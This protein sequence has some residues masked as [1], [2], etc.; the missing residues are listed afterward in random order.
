MRRLSF[1]FVLL[2]PGCAFFDAFAKGLSGGETGASGAIAG[3][4]AGVAEVIRSVPTIVDS[5]AG[6]GLVAG[7]IVAALTIWKAVRKGLAV[8]KEKRIDE[9]ATGVVKAANGGGPA[10]VINK[11]KKNG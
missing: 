5:A 11:A 6:S 10:S 7:V 1:T 2:L 3:A 4:G 9:V 8:A